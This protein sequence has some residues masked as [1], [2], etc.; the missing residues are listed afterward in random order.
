MKKL[1]AAT[2]PIEIEPA[3]MEA[4][5]KFEKE[6]SAH[7]KELQYVKG[8]QKY[9]YSCDGSIIDKNP[10]KCTVNHETQ[11]WGF[12]PCCHFICA[13]CH[14]TNAQRELTCPVCETTFTDPVIRF[15]ETDRLVLS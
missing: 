10:E 7:V 3:R 14:S 12:L 13:N 5:D 8:M 11:K 2:K 1:I 4:E 15:V 9:G 6:L